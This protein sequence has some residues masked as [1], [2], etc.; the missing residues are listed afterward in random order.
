MK[1]VLVKIIR[2]LS[3]S[4]TFR[5]SSVV[6]SAYFSLPQSIRIRIRTQ[7]YQ[8]TFSTLS[9]FT[10]NNLPEHNVELSNLDLPT[11]E[12]FLRNPHAKPSE[13]T[14]SCNIRQNLVGDALFTE[15]PEEFSETNTVSFDFW[16]TLIGRY[17]PAESIK[18]SVLMRLSFDIWKKNLYLNSRLRVDELYARRIEIESVLVNHK[19]EAHV[20]EVYKKLLEDFGLTTEEATFYAKLECHLEL[21]FTQTLPEVFDY[22][23][24]CG[25]RK[26]IISDYYGESTTLRAIIDSQTSNSKTKIDVIVSSEHFATKRDA[27]KLFTSAVIESS[28]SWVHVGD[29]PVSDGENS[30]LHGAKAVLVNRVPLSAWN[31]HSPNLETLVDELPASIGQGNG[32]SFLSDLGVVCYTLITS[33]LEESIKTGKKKIVYLSREGWILADSHKR[34]VS[35]LDPYEIFNL[36]GVHFECSRASTFFP[37]YSK[38]VEDGLRAMSHQYPYS[39]GTSISESMGL[40]EDLAHQ[41]KAEIGISTQLKT[42]VIWNKL[43]QNTREAIEDYLSTQANL[44][45]EYLKDSDITPE[46]SILC[47]I[48][49]RGTIQDSLSRIVGEN[50]DGVYLGLYLPFENSLSKGKKMGVLIDESTSTNLV[51]FLNFFGPLERA[52]TIPGY[53]VLRYEKL[54]SKLKI[55]PVYTDSFDGPSKA[56]KKLIDESFVD[57]SNLVFKKLSGLGV[58]G[59]DSATF[60]SRTLHNWYTNPTFAHSSVW[61]SEGHRESFGVTEGQHYFHPSQPR[62]NE[63]HPLTELKM[64]RIINQSQW[65]QG[66]VSWITSSTSKGATNDE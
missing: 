13:M 8:N 58:F 41:V 11:I 65:S 14:F 19:G 48:G 34:L 51:P 5:N 18:K 57:V 23:D 1:S 59:S 17:V 64:S 52:M 36:E 39:S 15:I 2:T 45:R 24:R 35:L 32:T 43:S 55:T 42:K 16:D 54:G 9:T 22:F 30:V 27:G 7:F 49:W 3:K 46:N 26:V 33:A 63:L 31:G 38:N 60:A 50:F 25:V 40:A 61:F 37:S 6:R 62:S 44:V 12:S 28:S 47:D 56:R 20:L 21:R 66:F 4:T 10:E 29:N 53:Q